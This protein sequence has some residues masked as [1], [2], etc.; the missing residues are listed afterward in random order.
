M[1]KILY[2]FVVAAAVVTAALVR[3][4]ENTARTPLEPCVWPRT[5]RERI[6]PLV[7][8]QPCVWPNRCNRA[9]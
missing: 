6:M 8:F 5:C 1:R 7:Q 2:G 3:F 9:T 4:S